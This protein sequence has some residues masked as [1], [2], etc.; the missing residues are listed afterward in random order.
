M[1]DK[2]NPLPS[3]FGQNVR[4]ARERVKW[5]QQQLSDRM[6]RYGVK[7]DTSAITRIEGDKRE[8]RLKEA[9]AVAAA[10]GVLLDDLLPDE[11]TDLV[12]HKLLNELDD[13]KVGLVDLVHDYGTARRALT[14][15]LDE[16]DSQGISVEH[17]ESMRDA[18]RLRAIADWAELKAEVDRGTVGRNPPYDETVFDAET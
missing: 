7:L 1:Q 3:T 16:L 2:Q 11:P 4:A 13:A 18:T 10:L 14:Q 6:A 15:V 5:T 12:A 17:Y 8:P 9:Q